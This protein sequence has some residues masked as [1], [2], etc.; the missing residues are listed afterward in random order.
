MKIATQHMFRPNFNDEHD[1]W[2]T[3]RVFLSSLEVKI[4]MV[5]QA[6]CGF[7]RHAVHSAFPAF[8]SC[9]PEAI[10]QTLGLDC[11]K[12]SI[13]RNPIS[14][15]AGSWRLGAGSNPSPNP[16]PQPGWGG[17]TGLR[18]WFTATWGTNECN[19]SSTNCRENIGGEIWEK[20]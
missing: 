1:W 15:G 3:D 14:R 9:W 18:P 8:F 2:V 20:Q 7:N 16:R 4:L 13:V 19:G 12:C 5:T 6:Q 10:G 17:W 11:P